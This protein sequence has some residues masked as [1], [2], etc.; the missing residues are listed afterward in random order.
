MILP[1]KELPNNCRT[2]R[3]LSF[4]SSD[5]IEP[6]LTNQSKKIHALQI[7]RIVMAMAMAMTMGKL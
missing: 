5:G 1:C 3:E 7:L 4:P 2:E 6:S